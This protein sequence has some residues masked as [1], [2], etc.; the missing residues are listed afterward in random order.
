MVFKPAL[1]ITE[2]IAN[3]LGQE[4]VEGR[5]EAGARIQELKLANK[6]SVSRGSV[7]EALLIL[8]R[9]HLIEIVPRKGAVVNPLT[10]AEAVDLIDLLASTEHRWLQSQLGCP[11]RDLQMVG[12]AVAQMEQGA[13]EG[14]T[15]DVFAGRDA[16]YSA[17]LAKANRYVAAVFECLL[18]TSQRILWIMIAGKHIDLHDVA[19]Y[20]RALYEALKNADS[21]R[22]EELL[23]AFAKRL[24]HL[25]VTV[26]S[27][28]GD[29]KR[30][31]TS[32]AVAEPMPL[33]AI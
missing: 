16:F 27:E 30:A 12:D 5:L 8:E 19:R 24:H 4:I 2:Q 21:Q 15:A 3:H 25:C 11:H 26:V 14:M 1:N 23:R 33:R 22:V 20:Y 29:N 17:L 28:R 9:R 13:R 7:R 31:K 18:P 6:L 10:R 32:A